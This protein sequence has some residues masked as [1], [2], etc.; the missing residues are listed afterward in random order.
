M[1]RIRRYESCN[2]LKEKCNR[3]G[4]AVVYIC[5][6]TK[7]KNILYNNNLTI[8]VMETKKQQSIKDKETIV[9]QCPMKC[10]GTKTYDHEG[11]C[12]VCKMILKPVDSKRT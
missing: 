7:F 9:Y 5:K 10:E 3:I 1:H 6:L 11:T 8:K 2:F 4:N 12:P